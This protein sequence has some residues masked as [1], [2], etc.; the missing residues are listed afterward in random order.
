MI[1]IYAIHNER[2]MNFQFNIN[3]TWHYKIYIDV[4]DSWI[5]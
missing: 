2:S 4:H 3:L 1:K 5:L